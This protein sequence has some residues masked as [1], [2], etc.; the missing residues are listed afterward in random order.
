LSKPFVLSLKPPALTSGAINILKRI[1][2]KNG[3]DYPSDCKL[4][5]VGGGS[6]NHAALMAKHLRSQRNFT[7]LRPRA[8]RGWLRVFTA[9]VNFLDY[10]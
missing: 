4:P 2:K 9:V 6:F 8:L 7:L 5:T 1:L 10:E 3:L